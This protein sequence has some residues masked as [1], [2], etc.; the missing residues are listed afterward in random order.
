MPP[1]T[2]PRLPK[3]LEKLT[4]NSIPGILC[5]IVILV[6]TGLPGS[7]FPHVKPVVGIDKVVHVLMYAFFAFLCIWGYRS[8]YIA[9][10]KS[11]RKRALS[12][13]AI[14]SILYGGITELMQEY[15]VPTRTG[16][17]V[18]FLADAIGTLLG[19]SIFSIFFRKKK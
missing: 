13:A 2:K 5:G 10:G 11:Y 18:D 9:N 12:L 3:S 14:I 6:L 4:R 19:I 17:W 15:L 16:D 8:Q 7:V 1:P